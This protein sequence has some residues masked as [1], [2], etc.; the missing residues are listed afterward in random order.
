MD[1]NYSRFREPR[2]FRRTGVAVIWQ[3]NPHGHPEKLLLVRSAKAARANA[4]VWL[5]PQGGIGEE[6]LLVEGLMRELEE[7]LG[8]KES[9]IGYFSPEIITS[10]LTG[11]PRL[12]GLGENP[13][14][15]EYILLSTVYI[16]KGELRLKDDEIAE[17]RWVS[18]AEAAELI[19]D[20]NQKD[21]ADFLLAGIEKAYRINCA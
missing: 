5:L 9:E 11:R 2:K 21:K 15:K 14:D 13:R 3:K 6:E 8:I 10:R 17:A 12:Q 7:E 16:G 4:K 20:T 1:G 18:R 19:L